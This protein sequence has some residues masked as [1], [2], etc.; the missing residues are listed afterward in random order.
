MGRCWR[1]ALA[2]LICAALLLMP[3]LTDAKTD[4]AW[5]CRDGVI[6]FNDHYCDGASGSGFFIGIPGELVQ[7][8]VTDRASVDRLFETMPERGDDYFGFAYFEFRETPEEMG[9][10]AAVCEMEF[11]CDVPETDFAICRLME[12][13]SD[14]I[15]LV[16]KPASALRTGESVTMFLLPQY[17]GTS[18]EWRETLEP[19]EGS[20]LSCTP[21]PDV[22]VTRIETDLEQPAYFGS[23]NVLMTTEDGCAAGM[24]IDGYVGLDRVINYLQYAEIP[25]ALWTENGV[26][27][28]C[29]EEISTPTPKPTP[30]PTQKPTP[31]P[32][33]K[34]TQKPTPKP[35]PTPKPAPTQKPT[36]KS[37]QKPGSTPSPKIQPGAETDV[38]A[39]KPTTQPD[40]NPSAAVRP[41]EK[42]WRNKNL[43][44]VLGVLAVLV[45]VASA[46]IIACSTRG[47]R[48][49]ADGSGWYCDT[50][51]KY[52]ETPYCA[53]CGRDRY[54]TLPE[55]RVSGEWSHSK[56]REPEPRP[57]FE[58]PATEHPPVAPHDIGTSAEPGSSGL[59]RKFSRPDMRPGAGVSAEPG[60]SGLK[61]KSSR[62]DMRPGVDVS[63]EPGRSRLKRKSLPTEGAPMED[64]VSSDPLFRPPDDL[65]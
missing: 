56:G 1:K 14:A 11:V 25:F 22:Y 3:G 58:R 8:I 12:P 17:N 7:Y 50:C 2:A 18:E 39:E 59:K 33:P 4:G 27:A 41:A 42:P 23:A 43:Y 21:D 60:S 61:R 46:V 34:P 32:T 6:A 13:I 48:K 16:L 51:G 19:L 5:E 10:D 28:V 9:G 52:N 38:P 53:A 24:Y 65:S 31:K 57:E 47:R 36:P 30:K 15:P 49:E 63:A 29:G 55:T 62:P 45:I 44:P 40:G 20:V 26:V 35:T 54:G 37:T 64:A